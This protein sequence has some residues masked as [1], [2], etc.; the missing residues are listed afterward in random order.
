M[1]E[2]GEDLSLVLEGGAV[3]RLAGIELPVAYGDDDPTG[4]VARL[5][6]AVRARLEILALAGEIRFP[7]GNP[8]RHGRVHT[9]V[10]LAD[11]RSLQVILLEEGLARIHPLPGESLCLTEMLQAED[12]ARN[13]RKGIWDS[14]EY[15]IRRADDLSL[16]GRNGLYELV[17]GRVISVGRGSRMVFLN[18]GRNWRRDFTVM[19][20]VAVEERLAAAGVAIDELAGRRV[21]VRGVIEESGGPAIRLDGPAA[22]EILGD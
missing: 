13:A 2:V 11:D 1:S 14:H 8:D 17:E 19:V 20:A 16:A 3:I 9:E 15:A 5:A 18:F 10:R 21:R 4:E 6:T 12:A 7:P 22:I